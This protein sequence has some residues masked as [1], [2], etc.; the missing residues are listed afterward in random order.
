MSKQRAH[1]Y[2]P[3]DVVR[4]VL[5]GVKVRSACGDTRLLTREGIDAAID[6]RPCGKCT[7]AVNE[8]HDEYTVRSARGWVALLERCMTDLLKQSTSKYSA[9]LTGTYR[10]TDGWNAP[11][12]G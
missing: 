9:T 5:L 10:F 6:L 7:A 4:S 11:L 2:T 12:A 1:M 3:D 8:A